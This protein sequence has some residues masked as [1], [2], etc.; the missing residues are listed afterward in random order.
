MVFLS[1][2][3][4]ACSQ[5]LDGCFSFMLHFVGGRGPT[6]CLLPNKQ[7]FLFEFSVAVFTRQFSLLTLL[8][9]LMYREFFSILNS[10]FRFQ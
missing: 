7:F 2:L 8:S 5:S 6:L 1:V 10:R 3:A 4:L 9:M